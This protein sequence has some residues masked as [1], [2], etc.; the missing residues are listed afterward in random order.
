MRLKLLIAVLALTLSGANA[1][2]ASICAAFC[3]STESV[4]S[5]VHLVMMDIKQ[6]KSGGQFW[7]A[8]ARFGTETKFG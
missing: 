7:R 8:L 4:G 1:G 3:M 2:V 6:M 5:A